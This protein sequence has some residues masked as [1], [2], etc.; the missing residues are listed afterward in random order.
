MQQLMFFFDFDPGAPLKKTWTWGMRQ[1]WVMSNLATQ[2]NCG[3]NPNQ[4]DHRSDLNHSTKETSRLK[5]RSRA[6]YFNYPAP[7]WSG[8]STRPDPFARAPH[9]ALC[10]SAAGLADGPPVGPG[11]LAGVVDDSSPD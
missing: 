8:L 4:Y 2:P 3:S 7:L 6:G 1:L 11:R 10:S 9:G 5:S